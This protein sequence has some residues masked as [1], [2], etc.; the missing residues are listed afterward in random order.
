MLLVNQISSFIDNLYVEI[1]LMSQWMFFPWRFI[2]NKWNHNNLKS[3]AFKLSSLI[4]R[5]RNQVEH[6]VV[7]SRYGNKQLTNAYSGTLQFWKFKKIFHKKIKT[8]GIQSAKWNVF[9]KE[10]T[11][12]LIKAFIQLI[13]E[14][15]QLFKV[16]FFY[17]IKKKYITCRIFPE[18]AKLHT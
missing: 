13:K 8:E 5:Q 11:F 7:I 14:M 17:W 10:R 9:Y 18:F 6:F 15:L 3:V 16:V 4:V 2:I 12:L 1:E